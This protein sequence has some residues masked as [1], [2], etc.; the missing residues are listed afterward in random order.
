MERLFGRLPQLVRKLDW[1]R[2]WSSWARPLGL[3]A[4]L[5]SV[6][7]IGH[8]AGRVAPHFYR[9]TKRKDLPASLVASSGAVSA[10]DADGRPGRPGPA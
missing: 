7:G 8:V 1:V 3:Q 9:F 5:G 2:D 10:F 6:T 4:R